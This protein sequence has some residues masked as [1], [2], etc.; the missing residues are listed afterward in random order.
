MDNERIKII[1]KFFK[2]EMLAYMWIIVMNSV[3]VRQRRAI[4]QKKAFPLKKLRLIKIFFEMI[5]FLSKKIIQKNMFKFYVGKYNQ[6]AKN[7]D[8]LIKS[9]FLKFIM[10]SFKKNIYN[11]LNRK[12][13]NKK[14]YI[15][16]LIH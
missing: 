2:P 7:T 15:C 9:W 12:I 5:F 13:F 11:E 3:Q 4:L 10:N 6:Y 1:V 8:Q 16:I 14:K